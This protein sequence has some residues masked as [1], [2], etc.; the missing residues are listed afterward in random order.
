MVYYVLLFYFCFC[1]FFFFQ[2]EDGI[3]DLTVTGVQTCAL[4]IWAVL[5]QRWPACRPSAGEG[6]PWGDR[7]DG[8]GGDQGQIDRSSGVSE[9]VGR[10]GEEEGVR[11]GAVG[12]GTRV[13]R[14]DPDD[15]RRLLPWRQVAGHPGAGHP[16]RVPGGLPGEELATRVA[17]RVGLGGRGER[18]ARRA[19]RRESIP[20]RDFEHRGLGDLERDDDLEVGDV[21]EV[22]EQDAGDVICS[23]ELFS[24]HRI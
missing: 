8:G 21:R 3:R 2:A 20:W 14:I 1:F 18:A 5:L 23:G 19:G 24:L 12:E 11:V 4:P 10:V 16:V 6:L 13:G 17:Q 7:Q 9:A 22:V 15:D